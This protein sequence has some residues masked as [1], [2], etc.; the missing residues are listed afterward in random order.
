MSRKGE[1]AQTPVAIA[2]GVW[3]NE[4]LD[5]NSGMTKTEETFL[6][7]IDVCSKAW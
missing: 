3:G 4:L 2:T 7:L 1:L 6:F 5:C